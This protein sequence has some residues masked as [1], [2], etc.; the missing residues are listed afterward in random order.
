MLVR[1]HT[2]L[3]RVRYIVT[4]RFNNLSYLHNAHENG[5]VYEARLNL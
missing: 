5:H 3:K 1:I 2:E 4:V